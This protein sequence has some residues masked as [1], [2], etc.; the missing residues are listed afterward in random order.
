M[1]PEI[2]GWIMA[3]AFSPDGRWL[4]GVSRDR[5]VRL[6]QVEPGPD[7]WKVVALWYDRTANNF[8][9]VDW[10]PDGR[11][12][13]TGDRSGRIAVWSFDPAADRWD[14]ATIARFAKLGWSGHPAW[15]SANA[16]RLAKTPVWSEAGHKVV[17]RVRHAPDGTRVA[18]TGGDGLLSVYEAATGAVAFRTGA[19]RAAT[20]HG[21]DWSPDGRFLAVGGGDK[22]IHV[23]EAATGARYDV[24]VGHADA[25]TAVGWSPDGR[26]LASTA[27]GPLISQATHDLAAGP[28]QTLKLWTWR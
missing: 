2:N 14:D 3:L 16:A 13:A 22:R 8:V 26:T 24:L 23:F 4:A 21:L 25:V 11:T 7:Q 9:S 20:L 5:T 28:D 6:W 27:G 19:P 12:L 18:A 15:F 10:A 1:L 17:W